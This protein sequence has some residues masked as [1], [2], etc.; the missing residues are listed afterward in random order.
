MPTVYRLTGGVVLAAAI[1]AVAACDGPPPKPAI[2]NDRIARN[3]DKWNTAV[4]AFKGTM[5]GATVSS[6]QANDAYNTLEKEFVA[7]KRA[8]HHMPA[9]SSGWDL[10]KKYQDYLDVEDEILHDEVKKVVNTVGDG[11]LSAA[12]KARKLTELYA[13]IQT[14]SR[15]AWDDLRSAQSEFCKAN[16]L[17][18]SAATGK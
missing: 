3:N 7:V 2:F 17:T 14:H 11:N 13:S 15:K 1:L 9:P 10:L 18:P 16:N 8:S 5:G 12:D 6:A 4:L